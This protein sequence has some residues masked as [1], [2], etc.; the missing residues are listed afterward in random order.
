[1]KFFKSAV[2]ILFGVLIIFGI[3]CL[4][5][6]FLG[7]CPYVVLSGSM[8]PSIQTGSIVFSDKNVREVNVGDVITYDAGSRYVTHRVV[9]KMK[10]GYITKGDANWEADLKP[11]PQNRVIGKVMFSVPGFG[12]LIFFLRTWPFICLLILLILITTLYRHFFLN[13]TQ[14]KERKTL[15]S[16]RTNYEDE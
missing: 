13:P 6:P 12:Y 9:C 8:E 14:R 10:E 4:L 11:V 3:C 5:L 16:V 7:I 15:I 1:M 2:H